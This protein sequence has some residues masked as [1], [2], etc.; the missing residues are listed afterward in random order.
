MNEGQRRY[1][2]EQWKLARIRRGEKF[3]SP[4]IFEA[5]EQDYIDNFDLDFLG[6]PSTSTGGPEAEENQEDQAIEDFLDQITA[7]QN[8]RMETP[9]QTPSSSRSGPPAPNRLS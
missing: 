4:T 5:N 2:M 8:N 3:D 7:N 6:S 9:P 1:A